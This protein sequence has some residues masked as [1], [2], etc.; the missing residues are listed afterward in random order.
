[1]PMVSIYEK[2]STLRLPYRATCPVIIVGPGTGLALFRGFI[3]NRCVTKKKDG[4]YM[5]LLNNYLFLK[6]AYCRNYIERIELSVGGIN[7]FLGCMLEGIPNFCMC[8]EYN[9]LYPNT[10]MP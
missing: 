2:K 1:M 8:I 6:G 7:C 9:P 10:S 3:E 4:E 5:L